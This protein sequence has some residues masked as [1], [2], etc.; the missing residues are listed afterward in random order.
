MQLKPGQ[1]D[2]S[3][4]FDIIEWLNIGQKN[5]PS[6]SARAASDNDPS[7]DL[8]LE[9]VRVRR[10]KALE[11][12]I[13]TDKECTTV[14]SRFACGIMTDVWFNNRATPMNLFGQVADADA[15]C[16]QLLVITDSRKG[17][18]KKPAEVTYT[19][20]ISYARSKGGL[21]IRNSDFIVTK[22][23][24]LLLNPD[25]TSTCCWREKPH[26][27]PPQEIW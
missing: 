20:R 5:Q 9:K 27:A 3:T 2:G 14:T 19:A 8:T 17:H 12:W 13:T 11:R 1:N 22:C 18:F 4:P 26:S 15:V 10:A 21:A 6:T 23:D 7:P 16:S 24:Y 25:G